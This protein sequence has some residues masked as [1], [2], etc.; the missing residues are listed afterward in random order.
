[1]TSRVVGRD[2]E[3]GEH[4]KVAHATV[5]D[6]AGGSEV[7]RPDREDV[8]EGSRAGVATSLDD[9]DIVGPQG[10]E[11]PLLGV[12]SAAEAIEQVLPVGDVAQGARK[13]DQSCAGPGRDQTIDRDVV[14]TALAQ[15]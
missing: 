15:Q 9:D 1:M 6:N 3:F 4:G 7:L 13:P 14:E 12:V 11:E 8:A 10:V 5:S 2:A